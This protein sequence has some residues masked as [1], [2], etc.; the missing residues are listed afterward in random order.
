MKIQVSWDAISLSTGKQ[1]PRMCTC[2]TTY[3]STRHNIPEDLNLEQHGRE[4]FKPSNRFESLSEKV[5]KLC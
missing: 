4:N 1:L 5:L 3:Q 2:V